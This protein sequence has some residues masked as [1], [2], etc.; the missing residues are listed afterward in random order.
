[1]IHSLRAAVKRL[2]QVH[3]WGMDIHPTARIANSALID[4]TWPRGI[5]I[6]ANCVLGEEAVVLAHD[7]TRGIYLDTRLGAGCQMG[8]RAIVLPGLTVGEDCVIAP[9]AVVTKDMPPGSYALG[10]PAA[11]TPRE[12]L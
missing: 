11:I 8:A 6:A 4:R 5:H 1:M 2:I 12:T 9:G 7:M 10:N 3:V